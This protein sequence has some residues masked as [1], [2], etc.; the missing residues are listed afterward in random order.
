MNPQQIDQFIDQIDQLLDNDEVSFVYL[1]DV[2]ANYCMRQSQKCDAPESSVSEK[3]RYG[4]WNRSK[5]T[6]REIKGKFQSME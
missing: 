4:Y 5:E 2:L 1:L 6:L 3:Y